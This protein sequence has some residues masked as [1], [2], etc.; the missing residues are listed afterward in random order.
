LKLTTKPKR[1]Y[2]QGA[3]AL[4]AERTRTSILVAAGLAFSVEPYDEVSLERIAATAGVTVQSVLRIFGS[5]E[6]LF[7]AAAQRA[8][9]EIVAQLR[10]EPES[11]P[12]KAVADMCAV[13]EEWGDATHRLQ[14]QVERVPAIRAALERGRAHHLAQVRALFGKRVREPRLAV[15]A[16]LLSLESYRHLRGQGLSA[17]AAREALLSAALALSA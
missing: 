17:R 6:A 3:R 12:A 2:R 11:D 8:F 4:A 14:A 10:Q 13:Y 5:K 9:Q 16:A 15:I 7:E 1:R